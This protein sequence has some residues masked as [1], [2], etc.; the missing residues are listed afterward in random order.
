[1]VF[2]SPKK[3]PLLYLMD[4]LDKRITALQYKLFRY[5]VLK[6]GVSTKSHFRK[7]I[8]RQIACLN[9]EKQVIAKIRVL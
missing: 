7:A 2:L 5:Y 1:M 9:F 3:L 4:R 6:S 8:K